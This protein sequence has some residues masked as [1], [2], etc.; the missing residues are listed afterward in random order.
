MGK[1]TLCSSV[2]KT[3]FYKLSNS[4]RGFSLVRHS[5]PTWRGFLFYIYIST[6]DEYTT[7][8][9]ASIS[10]WDQ[11]TTEYTA[12]ISTWDQYT[13]EYTASIST[14]DY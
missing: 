7:E 11:Y 1:Q 3:Q 14:W 5:F 10:I 8:Y 6:W 2:N 12:S 9:T 13:T 4:S